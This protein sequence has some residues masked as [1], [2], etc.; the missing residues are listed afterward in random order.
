MLD[1]GVSSMQLDDPERGFSFQGDGPLDMRMGASG[2]TA[3]DVVNTATRTTSPTSSSICGDERRSR[4]IARAIVRAASK[5][6]SRARRSWSTL[7]ERVLRPSPASR[8]PATR[9]FQALR[10][11]VNDELGELARGAWRRPSAC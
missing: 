8:H 9:T 5:R 2:P 1:I 3:A 7:V 10:I 11:Y 4:A 6:R